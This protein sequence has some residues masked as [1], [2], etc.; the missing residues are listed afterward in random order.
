MMRFQFQFLKENHPLYS[1]AEFIQNSQIGTSIRESLFVFPIIEAIHVLALGLSVGTIV[2]FDLRLLG[3]IMPDQPISKIHRQVMPWAL[4]GF[5]LMFLSG[6]LLFWA[7]ALKAYV[8]FYFRL[9]FLFLFLAGC[10]A[11]AFE[12]AT[13]PSIQTWD[14][15]PAV[16][17]KVKLAGLFSILLWIA[18][19]T[20]GRATAYHLL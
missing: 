8:S 7:N 14:N 20:F 18:V 6:A 3:V 12:L 17:R 2:W 19:I 4:L 15:A 1:L 11:L 9:K 10:N 16:P 5:V 13:K